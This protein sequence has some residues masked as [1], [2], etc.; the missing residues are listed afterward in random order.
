MFLLDSFRHCLSPFNV[1]FCLI[2]IFVHH[3]QIIYEN[4]LTHLALPPK[5]MALCYDYNNS[6]YCLVDQT[7]EFKLFRFFLSFVSF[8][9]AHAFF[10]FYL[11]SVLVLGLWLW[12]W[13]VLVFFSF[14]LTLS[15]FNALVLC[16]VIYKVEEAK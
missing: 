9:L 11:C 5:V 15:R 13:L 1:F 3:S 6:T 4:L 14:T 7:V 16:A 10:T 12:F 8:Y 2:E